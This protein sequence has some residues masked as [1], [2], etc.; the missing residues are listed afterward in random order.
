MLA[1]DH[2]IADVAL[3]ASVAA[4]LFPGALHVSMSTISVELSERLTAA[5][6][7]KSQRYLAAP[8]FGRPMRRPPPSCSS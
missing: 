6:E 7:A 8:M 1:D 3:G 5:H 2:V 4:S